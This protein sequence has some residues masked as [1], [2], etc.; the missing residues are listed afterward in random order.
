MDV[1]ARLRELAALKTG[2]PLPAWMPEMDWGTP[3][4]ELANQAADE[5][6]RLREELASIK[7]DRHD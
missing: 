4:S 3:V 6:K 5:I 2:D 1:L 7:S